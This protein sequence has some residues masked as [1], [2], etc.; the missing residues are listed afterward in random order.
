MATAKEVFDSARA[1]YL[2]DA[3]GQVFTDS[4][5]LPHLKEA[6]RDL[7]L[8]LLINGLPVIR[9][10]S[11]VIPVVALST[12]LTLP[13]D[14]IEAISLK[15][16]G[17]SSDEWVSMTEKDFEPDY[18]Q[19]TTLIFWCN[20]DEKIMLVGATTNRE[21]LL[22]YNK[23]LTL[24][25]DETS[26]MGFRL[27]EVFLAAQT[28]QYAARALGSDSLADDC[29]KAAELKLDLVVR[30][31]I[32]GQQSLPVRRIPYRRYRRSGLAF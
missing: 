2:N 20:R 31:N 8:H 6:H 9:E 25:K 30:A 32:K 10:K 3:G 17:S 5:L 4:V 1:V 12:E 15:E 19:S 13:A 14:F 28:A 29:L 27:A 24:P 22:R 21:V 7:Q 11:D 26:Q 16:R 18:Q 23:G